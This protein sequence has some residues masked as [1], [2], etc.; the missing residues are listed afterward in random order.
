MFLLFLRLARFICCCVE[1]FL[2]SFF[3][4]L[5]AIVLFFVVCII[6]PRFFPLC[7]YL[8]MILSSVVE[9]SRL[10]A[11]RSLR[12]WFCVFAPPRPYWTCLVDC[13][14]SPVFF[15]RVLAVLWYIVISLFFFLSYLV[16]PYFSS[17][18]LVFCVWSFI[19]GRIL[20]CSYPSSAHLLPSLPRFVF[21]VFVSFSAFLYVY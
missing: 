1:S 21:F 11:F 5:P 15:C 14:C 7:F 16:L 6:S 19:M 10:C 20:C 8:V 9:L 4:Y 13:S 2:D 17:L 18:Y 12:L 3:V